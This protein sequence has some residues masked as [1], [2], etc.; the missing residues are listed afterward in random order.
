MERKR[1]DQADRTS[2]ERTSVSRSTIIAR[3]FS[4][5]YLENAIGCVALLFGR[6]MVV[7]V[8]WQ[9]RGISG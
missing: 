9:G 3:T 8:I 1:F 6:D 4:P 7:I 2:Y 5:A